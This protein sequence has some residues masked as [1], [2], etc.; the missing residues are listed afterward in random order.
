MP[1]ALPLPN[2]VKMA[3]FDDFLTK[4]AKF[5][6]FFLRINPTKVFVPHPVGLL[7]RFSSIPTGCTQ[8]YNILIVK[9][10]KIEI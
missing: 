5:F 3:K 2:L 8:F 1:K 7:E 9:I 10:G 4:L 6:V